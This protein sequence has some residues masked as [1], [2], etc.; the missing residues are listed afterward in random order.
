MTQMISKVRPKRKMF[1]LRTQ[2]KVTSYWMF[3]GTPLN[4]GH[5]LKLVQ[6]E[7][8]ILVY[9]ATQKIFITNNHYHKYHNSKSVYLTS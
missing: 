2:F 3:A 1:C 8:T 7:R 4:L 6:T 5:D 9:I